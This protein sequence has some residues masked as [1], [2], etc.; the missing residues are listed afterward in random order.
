[1]FKR[2]VL[3][4]LFLFFL[5]ACG[6]S[7]QVCPLNGTLSDKLVCSIPQVYGPFALSRTADPKQSV[8]LTAFGHEA[9]F[10]NDFVATFTPIN[11]AVGIQV[12]QLPVASPSSGI[13]FVYNP[14][15]KTFT[16]STDE[17][18]GPIIGER[19][20]TIGYHKLFL[21]FSYQYFNFSSIDGL[22]MSTLSSVLQH[23]PFPP[24]PPNIPSCGKQDGLKGTKYD[25]NPC[26]VRDFIQT[27]NNID[28]QVHQYTIYLTYGI[29][30]HLDFSAAIP[31][32]DARMSVQSN[33]TIVPNSVAPASASFPGNVFHQFNRNNPALAQSCGQIPAGQ[34]CLQASF[35]D[36][37]KAVGIG[38]AV[39][40]G[41]Y[42][43]Y[44]GE[45]AGFALGVDVRLPSGDEL[46]F[47]G[48]G[49][50]GV[51]PFG[52]LSY[53]A[54]VSPH[55]EV[56]YEWNGESTLAG[57]SL[58]PGTTPASP[59]GS[60]PSRFVYIVGADVAVT[61]RMTAAFDIY[62]QR[63]FRAPQLISSPYTDLGKCSDQACTTVTPGT[64]HPNVDQTRTDYNITNASL[65]LKLRLFANL[66]ITAN[67]LLKLDNAGLRALAV[68]LVG[69]SYN[70]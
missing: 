56:G 33:T 44:R 19:A 62:G 47:L 55:A 68:P 24:Q 51:K 11:E 41:K 58:V 1:M 12:S 43:V 18:L 21:G 53:E 14:S 65:G 36:S 7:A 37:R 31:F 66:V 25:N 46:N 20:S 13:T 40:R 29:T 45:R 23:Q 52:V 60:L 3:A 28:L 54:R 8:L 61:K 35:S 4:S 42:T 15:L 49:A 39:L 38:D 9:H 22:N 57:G 67:V 10:E 16:P 48:S 17:S 27:T 26:F 34:A 59:K 69:V 50:T 5:G 32:L 70:F 2:G 64:T 6:A 30:R 63:L